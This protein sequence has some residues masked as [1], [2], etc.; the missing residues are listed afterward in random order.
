MYRLLIADDEALEREGLELMIQRMMPG[1]FH[2]LHAE[3]G[4]Q[5]IEI[6]E[7]QQPDIIFMDI[8]M[9][10]IQG[11]DA[12]KKIQEHQPKVKMIL[13][14]AYDYF[15]YAKEALTLGVRDY[16]LK[17][18]RREKIAE[19]LTKLAGEL[20]EEKEMRSRELGLQEKISQLLPL[21][22]SE[23]SG[24]LMM[25]TVQETDFNGL[26][27]L[28]GYSFQ[29]G[30]CIVLSIDC[31]KIEETGWSREMLH[32]EI[33][34]MA[35]LSHHALVS[36]LIGDQMAI[37][38][39]VSHKRSG[40]PA[41][42]ENISSA[43]RL[44]IHA[45][46][47]FGVTVFTGVGS[48]HEGAEGLKKSYQEA[49]EAVKEASRLNPVLV[50]EDISWSRRKISFSQEEKTA[51]Q[52]GMKEPNTSSMLFSFEAAFSRLAAE[53]DGNLLECKAAV[54]ALLQ[55]I[56][57]RLLKQ[58]IDM[59][60]ASSLEAESLEDLKDSAKDFLENALRR[61]RLHKGSHLSA[62][63]DEA[64]SF[65][66]R[67]FA[68]DLSMEQTADSVNLSPYYFSKVFKAE[69]GVSFID[70]LTEVR[71]EKAKEFAADPKLSLKE[72]CY[73]SGYKDPN[74]FSRVFKKVTGITPTEYRSTLSSK[75]LINEGK[76]R[77]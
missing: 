43:E 64:K 65:I 24:M 22:E 73:I 38:I 63:V 20:D 19:V 25:N 77:G 7:E 53:T 59:A 16:L 23:L 3:T 10:G 54:T 14:T 42:K 76:Q 41:K 15:A 18:A 72:I 17:P 66:R 12:I 30:F 4:R 37:F 67:H 13:I 45:R 27:N 28:I 32:E 34:S 29:N 39:S 68:D 21:A 61:T 70:F 49:K 57:Q 75:S 47:T 51:I 52:E 26:G 2:I 40:F 58:G 31:S 60:P 44:Q 36:P 48:E 33:K 8:K 6:A 69:S 11:I 56:A 74:Y 1:V 55:E 50:Y 5:A 71:I 46:E 35:K 62:A 9:P